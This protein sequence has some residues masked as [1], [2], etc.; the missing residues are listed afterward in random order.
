MS[1]QIKEI[2][3]YN[4][5]GEKRIVYFDINAVN[6]ITGAS[7]TGKSSIIHIVR[8][9]LGE[10]NNIP[11]RKEILEKISWF[12]IRLVR[13]QEEL[14]IARLNPRSGKLS[15]EEIYFEKRHNLVLPPLEQL[16]QNINLDGLV[17]LLTKFSGIDDYEFEPKEGQTRN[18]GIAHIGKAII[19]CFQKQG[20]VGNQDFLFHR[21]GEPF[22]PQSIKDYMPFF[23]GAV[24]K[25]YVLKKS[26]LNQLKNKLRRLQILVD[27]RNLIKGDVFNRAH[28]LIAEAVSFGLLPND[29]TMPQSWAEIKSVLI[30]AIEENPEQIL[31]EIEFEKKINQLFEK[32]KELHNISL[33]ISD[34]IEALEALKKGGV[35]FAQE[36]NEQRAR[37]SSIGLLPVN[38]G[39]EQKICP[40]CESELT[41]PAPGAN[42]IQTNLL[43]ISKQLT[44]VKTDLP[45]IKKLIA[46]ANDRL[47]I[48]LKEIRNLN[49]QMQAIQRVNQK[50]E[51]IQ[52][53]NEKCALIKG[54]LG[55]YLETIVDVA[56]VETE[57]DEIAELKRRIETLENDIDLDETQDR[58]QSILLYI[59]QE[60]TEMAT[61]LQLEY[62]P[63]PIRIDPKKLTVVAD[64]EDGEV[65]MKKMGSEHTWMSLHVITHLALH[66]WFAKKRLPVPHFIFFDQPSQAYFPP[67]MSDNSRRNSDMISVNQLFHLIIDKV[68]DAG[69]Q[70]IILEHVDIQQDWYQKMIR[71]KWWDEE[72][73]LVP[74]SWI[75]SE[76]K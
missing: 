42:D 67:E 3:L 71:E 44:G 69:F 74:V 61:R 50:I 25:N 8:Y 19:Y 39:L 6:I 60:M 11:I 7:G 5:F 35:G 18:P 46:D 47:T 53:I 37:L 38:R 34:E 9:C 62:S 28:T 45:H 41:K 43:Q 4:L 15:S 70:V 64:T 12:G 10:S 27:D 32:R 26:E 51:D 23:M 66:R 31:P 63:H 29:Q 57:N 20:E 56:D 14:F 52:N 58:L 65:T 36:A 21:Q 72:K 24:D 30:S 16:S 68:K 40:F 2:V 48:V 55:L 49:S 17:T 76:L 13:D 33:K 75:H 1:F 54:R 22:L 73:K 59:S